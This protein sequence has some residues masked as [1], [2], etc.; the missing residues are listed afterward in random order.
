[1]LPWGHGGACVRPGSELPSSRISGEQASRLERIVDGDGSIRV[2]PVDLDPIRA[3]CG[4]GSG[5]AIARLLA[6]GSLEREKE[7]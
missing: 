1:M 2:V 4:S 6:D 7:R 5:G 3:V